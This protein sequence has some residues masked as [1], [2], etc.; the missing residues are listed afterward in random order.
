MGM[1]NAAWQAVRHF[2]LYK[3]SPL[4]TICAVYPF[5]PE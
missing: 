4:V 2:I 1:E 3:R 5:V